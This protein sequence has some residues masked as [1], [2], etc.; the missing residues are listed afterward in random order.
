MLLR[1]KSIFTV[2]IQCGVCQN[3]DVLQLTIFPNKHLHRG[4]G[5]SVGISRKIN[6]DFSAWAEEGD[7]S[8][9]QLLL[10]MICYRLKTKTRHYGVG[11]LQKDL[12]VK[13]LF[14]D[15]DSVYCFHMLQ[16]YKTGKM[17][18]ENNMSYYI[19]TEHS[20]G[21]SAH[22]PGTFPRWEPEWEIF[23]YDWAWR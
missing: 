14:R 21:L 4:N 1:N 19:D 16:A 3:P 10:I 18:G 9:S 15:E 11:R 5:S 2:M 23:A 12:L 7:S 8:I 20:L 17:S 6:P 13:L 22:F